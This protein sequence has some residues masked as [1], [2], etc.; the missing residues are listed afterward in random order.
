MSYGVRT[1]DSMGRSLDT[2][3][4]SCNTYDSFLI[5]SGT[6]GSKSYPELANQGY[7]LYA[8][9]QR[10]SGSAGCTANFTTIDYPGDV[11]R[12]SWSTL[13]TGRLGPLTQRVY[14]MVA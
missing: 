14:V 11:P 1:V 5:T 2:S 9:C 7:T 6:S 13:A 10:V 3:A 12:V 4:F 8:F